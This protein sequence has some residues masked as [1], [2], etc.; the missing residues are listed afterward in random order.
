MDRVRRR[1]GSDALDAQVSLV[2]LFLDRE[3]AEAAA[4]ADQE[5]RRALDGIAAPGPK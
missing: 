1:G 5:L 2:A 4:Q 3:D